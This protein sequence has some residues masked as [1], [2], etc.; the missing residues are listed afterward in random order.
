MEIATRELHKEIAAGKNVHDKINEKVAQIL[1]DEQK[2]KWKEMIGKPPSTAAGW[3][4]GNRDDVEEGLVD[5]RR[6]NDQ[7]RG[8][9][10]LDIG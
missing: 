7:R 2:K 9:S 3:D 8:N 4:L 10:P 1:S 6:I 5:P